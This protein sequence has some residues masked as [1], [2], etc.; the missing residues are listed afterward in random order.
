[1]SKADYFKELN[2]RLRGLPEK[3]RNNILSVYEELFQKAIANG[4]HEDE[5][6]QSLGYPRVPNWEA[7]RE[8]PQEKTK[9]AAPDTDWTA[10]FSKPE[11]PQSQPQP[12]REPIPDTNY[13][14]NPQAAHSFANMP[15]YPYPYPAK[16]ESSVKP[17]I[18]SIMLGFFNLL[19]VV[20]PWF[21]LFAALIALFVGGFALTIAPVMGVIGSMWENSGQDLKLIIF[22][23]LACF[24]LGIILTTSA[25]WL[26]KWFFK[27]TWKYIQFNAKLI[28]GA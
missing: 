1:M 22:A 3:E 14:A 6:A 23:M 25:T 26:I 5:V 21:G 28:K 19:V 16:P 20:G 2:Y 8:V 12:R 7:V 11:P 17:I 18:V 24:G 9:P 15:P 13:Y 10:S 4:K 27:I